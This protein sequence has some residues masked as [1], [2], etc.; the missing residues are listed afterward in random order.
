MS[1]QNKQKRLIER[2][3]ADRN[4]VGFDPDYEYDK[5]QF[6]PIEIE[7]CSDM[8]MEEVLAGKAKRKPEKD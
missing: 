1:K 3:A 5:S 2:W 7:D 8:T 6:K 4:P